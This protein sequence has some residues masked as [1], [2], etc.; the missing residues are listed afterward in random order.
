M[1][2]LVAEGL[3]GALVFGPYNVHAC[4]GLKIML[5]L[6]CQMGAVP[7]TSITQ[8]LGRFFI[9]LKHLDT[10]TTVCTTSPIYTAARIT[11]T[12]TVFLC[13]IFPPKKVGNFHRPRYERDG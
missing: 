13:A 3:T 2:S 12:T 7:P 6:S 9:P 4:S 8:R 1:V 5:G 10:L 11:S